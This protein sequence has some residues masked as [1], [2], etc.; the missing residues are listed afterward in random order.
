M[1]PEVIRALDLESEEGVALIHK[2]IDMIRSYADR[3]HHAK[4]EE[5]LFSCFD[6]NSDILKV[7]R[8]DH[9]T[10]RSHVAA[11]VIGVEQKN[12]DAVKSH[13]LDR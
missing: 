11:L 7:M 2:G 8:Q 4:E 6:E 10:A 13:L 12:A 5:I 3:Y 9:T 1:I